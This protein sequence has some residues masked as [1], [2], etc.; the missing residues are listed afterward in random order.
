MSIISH[1]SLDQAVAVLSRAI[2]ALELTS[3]VIRKFRGNICLSNPKYDLYVDPGQ[4]AF[5]DIPND[6]RKRMR[7]LMDLIPAIKRPVT[8]AGLADLVGLE[9]AVVTE[10]LKRWNEKDLLRID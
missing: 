4:I 5:G 2:E 6:L 7:D 10:Y 8:T 3:V 1:S 9:E